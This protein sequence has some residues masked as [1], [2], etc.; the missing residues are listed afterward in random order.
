MGN[1]MQAVVYDRKLGQPLYA[2]D[3]EMAYGEMSPY[4]MRVWLVAR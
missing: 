3:A 1:E 2:V 4:L